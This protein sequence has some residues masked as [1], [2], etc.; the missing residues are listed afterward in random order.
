[1]RLVNPQIAK[2]LEQ[3]KSLRIDLGSGTKPRAGFYGLDQIDARGVDIVADLNQ[4]L[5]LLPDNCAEHVFSSHALEHV[6]RLRYSAGASP[7][8][9]RRSRNRCPFAARNADAEAVLE[10]TENGA[11]SAPSGGARPSVTPGSGTS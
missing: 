8:T 10:M 3:G 2:D 11:I 5:D 1:M 7:T 6:E 4:P 9:G